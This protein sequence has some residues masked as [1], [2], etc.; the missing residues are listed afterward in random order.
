[1]A[2]MDDRQKARTCDAFRTSKQVDKQT[3]GE[4]IT[5]GPSEKYPAFSIIVKGEQEGKR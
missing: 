1:M 2:H 5:R 4:Q 3:R